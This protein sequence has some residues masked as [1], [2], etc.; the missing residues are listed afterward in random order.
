MVLTGLHSRYLVIAVASALTR[1][2]HWMAITVGDPEDVH[3][4]RIDSTDSPYCYRVYAQDP[5]LMER[6]PAAFAIP[7]S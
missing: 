5:P 3:W 6:N 4:F 2:Q 1:R 7:S